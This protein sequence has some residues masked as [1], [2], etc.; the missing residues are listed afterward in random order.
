MKN[1]LNKVLTASTSEFE[2]KM[3]KIN[4]DFFGSLTRVLKTIFSSISGM[5]MLIAGLATF[6]MLVLAMINAERRK[7][8][9]IAAGA[10]LIIALLALSVYSVF[11]V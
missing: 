6:V 1:I 3:N 11:V 9:L 2:G 8:F 10:S 4:S 5:I 7:T